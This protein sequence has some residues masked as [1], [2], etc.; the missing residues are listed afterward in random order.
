MA[1]VPI[2]RLQLHTANDGIFFFAPYFANWKSAFLSKYENWLNQ[3]IQ[4]TKIV[5]SPLSLD[6]SP[7]SSR[8]G[9]NRIKYYLQ[10]S[11]IHVQYIGGR[12]SKDFEE[13]SLVRPF[14]AK[15]RCKN[16]LLLRQ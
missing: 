13:S 3:E 8:S 10:S 12:P 4:F 7:S 14:K 6:P 15:N 2:T 9:K 16:C 1:E 11:L 5:V